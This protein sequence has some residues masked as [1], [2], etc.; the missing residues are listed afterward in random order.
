FGEFVKFAVHVESESLEG[1]RR[2]M[3]RNGWSPPQRLLD[4]RREFAGAGQFSFGPRSL[5]GAGHKACLPLLTENGD[6]SGE[7][8]R[9]EAVD[10][11]RG[12]RSALRHTHV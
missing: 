7:Q 12:G 10:D 2:G 9:L 4:D 3:D 8:S 5:D 1:P 11:V 6:D